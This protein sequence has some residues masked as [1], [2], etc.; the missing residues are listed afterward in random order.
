MAS[1]VS[2]HSQAKLLK[3]QLFHSNQKEYYLIANSNV[4]NFDELSHFPF[5]DESLT[6]S[7]VA[8]KSALP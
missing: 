8:I 2:A 3:S 1:V 4:L 6:H 7:H 5:L